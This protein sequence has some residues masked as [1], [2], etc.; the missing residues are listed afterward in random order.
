[1]SIFGVLEK[2][3]RDHAS[4]PTSLLGPMKGDGNNTKAKVKEEVT[5]LANR[6]SLS[7]SLIRQRL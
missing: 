7:L 1:M 4:L 5:Q 3:V 2:Q 6:T